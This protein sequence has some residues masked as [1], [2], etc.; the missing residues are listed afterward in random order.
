M[1]IPSMSILEATVLITIIAF[2]LSFPT[3]IA[4]AQSGFPLTVT[5]DFGRSVTINSSPKR[6]VSTAPSNTELLF[7]LG[8]GD[9]VVGV[10]RYCDWPPVVLDKVKKNEITLIGG[11]ADPNLEAVVSLSPDLVLAATDLQFEFVST[12]QKRGMIV[13]ALNP[14]NLDGILKNIGL[15]GTICGKA[16]A[17]DKL[18]DNL[19]RRSNYI[20]NRVT[21]ASS[22]PKVYHELWYDPLMSFGSNTPAD[23]LIT[24]AGGE[25][26]FRDSPTMYP[27]VNSEMV[28]QKDPD[29][30]VYMGGTA[31]ADFEKRAGWNTIK[32][33][34]EGKIYTINENL[35]N[36]QGPRIYDGLEN[37][38]SILHPE[39]FTGT[40]HYN[41]SIAVTS[42]STVFAMIFDD[43]RSLLN[44]TVIGRGGSKAS[45]RVEIPQRLIKGNPTVLVDG[46]EKTASITKSQEAYVLDFTTSLSTRNIVIG[47][48]QTIPEFKD[49]LMPLLL[50][51]LAA[52]AV[53]KLRINRTS[54]GR[55]LENYAA[56]SERA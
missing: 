33:V 36:R 25:N 28:I 39:L 29:I 46:A 10:T 56:E 45:I 44:F 11:Y 5:D 51:L 32:A 23:E 3:F 42:N 9:L 21:A 20:T 54:T 50:P 22:K 38:A 53:L 4:Q 27:I 40:I 16:S 43:S 48:T 1:D 14:K 41:S 34:K 47:G 6:I 18:I 19:Q 35:V 26:I 8:A 12:L 52:F 30:I 13:I 15:A 7:A 24:K 49:L 17:A 37:F 2:S 55:R 31:K